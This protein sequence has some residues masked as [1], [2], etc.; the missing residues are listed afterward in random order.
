MARST[1]WIAV[2]D[3]AHATIYAQTAPGAPLA[4]VPDGVLTSPNLKGREI[5]SDRPGRSFDS[6][7]QG[8]HAMESE[9]DPRRQETIA[10]VR[11]VA[12]R[13]EDHAK[14]GDFDRLILVA[15][16]RTLGELRAAL[17]KNAASR[18]AAEIPKDFVALRPDDLHRR[19]EDELR[20]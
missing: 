5:V 15:P 16:P 12:A 18:I 9:V 11:E 14:R 13:L 3:S 19:I 10:F 8:R 4:A 17:G 7:G 6:A 2:A 20:P 1:T